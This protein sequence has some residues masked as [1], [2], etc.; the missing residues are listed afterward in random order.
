MALLAGIPLVSLLVAPALKPGKEAWVDLGPASSVPENQPTAF[1]LSY[2]RIDGWLESD[3]LNTV[4][5]VRLPGQKLFVLSNICT[6][7][8]C[9]VRWDDKTRSFFCPCHGG[10]YDVAGR[11]LAGPPPRPLERYTYRIT[12]GV[13]QV[14]VDAG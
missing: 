5:A 11:V 13:L 14:R 9:P 2:Q 7:L 1:S 6:H 4:Y 3:V 10:V 12:R 8:G